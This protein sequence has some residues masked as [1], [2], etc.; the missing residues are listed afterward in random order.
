MRSGVWISSGGGYTIWTDAHYFVVIAS[1]DSSSS[2]IYCGASRIRYTDKGI[3]RNQTLRYRHTPSTAP[4]FFSDF[5]M[6][7]E[8]AAN[9]VVETPLQIDE[10]KFCP[11]TCAM[12]QGVIYDSITEETGEYVLFSTCNGDQEKLFKD[13]RSVYLPA[14]GGEAW[15]YRIESF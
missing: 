10:S 1:G 4:V 8:G 13:G 2:N 7:S 6:F 14:G 15:S 11:G 5:S 12:D 9:S 3:A